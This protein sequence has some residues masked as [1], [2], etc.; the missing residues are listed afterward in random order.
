MGDVDGIR[1]VGGLVG[2][3]L[4]GILTGSHAS[5]DVTGR[6]VVGGLVGWNEDGKLSDSYTE[7]NV[8]GYV[9]VGGLIG[10]NENDVRD[11]Y[12][13]GTVEGESRTGAI[14]GDLNAGSLVDSRWV[15]EET[16]VPAVGVRKPETTFENVTPDTVGESGADAG[17]A[18]VSEPGGERWVFDSESDDSLSSPTVVDGKAYVGH[19]PYVYAIDIEDGT[20]EWKFETEGYALVAPTVAGDVVYVGTRLDDN[21]YALDASTGSEI[22][23]HRGEDSD[24]PVG[25]GTASTTVADGKLYVV[26]GS[27]LLALDASTGEER[28][29]FEA[30]SNS[31]FSASTV[32]D[33]TVYVKSEDVYALNAST[34]EKEW[35]FETDGENIQA[36]S[37]PT[38]ADDTVYVGQGGEGERGSQGA[39]YAI[40][41]S[42]GTEKWSTET[43]V[44]WS[45]PTVYEGTVYVGGH[46]IYAVDT[47][48][49][50]EEWM[51]ESKGWS[52][53]FVFSSP[54]VANGTVYSESDKYLHAVDADTGEE[55]WR[56]EVENETGIASPTVVDGTVYVGSDDGKL[57]AVNADVSGSSEG[58][59]VLLGTLGHHHTWAEKQAKYI[60][61]G[62]GLPVPT[63][64]LVA[65]VL[66]VAVLVGALALRRL[67]RVPEK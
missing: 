21:T 35:S 41:A 60:D 32:V 39:V 20:E 65:G 12:A 61:V 16:D 46:N 58:S 54:T 18:P 48:T 53:Q 19:T 29:R 45:T 2:W 6:W 56:F 23:T 3:N 15:G 47:D 10:E 7:G 26:E 63:S 44:A 25:G 33:E 64:A 24:N 66:I 22:W 51:Y 42:E 36:A 31:V 62:R 43:R 28:W 17:R 49:G 1:R 52:E 13:E 14:I 4:D 59:R 37:S 50:E 27:K 67:L 5:G 40:D 30:E 34:G 8:E 11:T 55:L 38:V 9:E 57:Y